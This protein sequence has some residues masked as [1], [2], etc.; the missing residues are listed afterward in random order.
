[1]SVIEQGLA[2]QASTPQASTRQASTRRSPARKATAIAAAILAAALAAAGIVG[3]LG[4]TGAHALPTGI[5][6][7]QTR[8]LTIHKFEQPPA[9]GV[10]GNGTAVDTTGLRPLDGVEYTV[11][12][13]TSYDG[14]AIDLTDTES[15][16][17]LPAAGTFDPARAVFAAPRVGT[18]EADGSVTFGSAPSGGAGTGQ[19]LPLGLYWVEHT[20]DGSH[21]IL[22]RDAPF[23]VTVPMPGGAAGQWRYQ[24]H[25]YPKSALLGAVKTVDETGARGLGDRLTW[26]IAVGIPHLPAGQHLDDLTITD[27]LPA[28]LAFESASLAVVDAAGA[29]VT[30]GEGTHYSLGQT[31]G[32]VSLVFAP[33]GRTLLESAGGGEVRLS[34]VT[35][36]VDIGMGTIENEAAVSLNNASTRGAARSLWGAVRI[37]KTAT[38]SGGPLAGAEFQLFE[39]L[40][41]AR[42]KQ[43]PV[44]VDLAGT[45][46][47]TFVTDAAGLATIPGLLSGAAA[48][49]SYWIVETR[50]PD[51][52][53]GSDEP[54]E[55]VVLPGSLAA[56]LEVGFE[57]RKRPSGFQLPIT[58]TAGMALLLVAGLG[59]A[60]VSV[61]VIA[62][63]RR[64]RA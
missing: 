4:A 56:P 51:G 15:W 29:P 63:G 59:L 7:T 9:Q 41:D 6:E 47:D 1:M 16:D 26:Q 2:L 54:V 58:G 52:Y 23:L 27:P 42:A 20:G 61:G 34:I 49:R 19:S 3:G 5:D 55:I 31:A 62:A 30:L 33:A 60:A 46:T 21:D 43:N 35:R 10:P 37:A 17:R 48:G 11:R 25:A 24:V 64:K 57:N 36:V 44:S 39:T 18:T 40:T 14:Q 12:Q 22:Q 8:T 50:A 13:V 28:T 38:G 53:I 45:P 32:T